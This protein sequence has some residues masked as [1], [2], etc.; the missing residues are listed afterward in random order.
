LTRQ[1]ALAVGAVVILF[2][3]CEAFPLGLLVIGA[4]GFVVVICGVGLQVVLQ[5]SLRHDY[6]GRVLGLWTVAN[7]AGPGVGGALLGVLA[8]LLGLRILTQ[9]A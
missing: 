1:A 7:V 8:Q 6:R 5:S 9:R 3:L 2:S 4:L